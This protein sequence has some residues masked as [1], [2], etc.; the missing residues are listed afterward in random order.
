MPVSLWLKTKHTC[1]VEWT[2][3]ITELLR[4]SYAGTVKAMEAKCPAHALQ[5]LQSSTA[6][7]SRQGISE[8][9]Q[10]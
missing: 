4:C 10:S 9:W 8:S 2:W 3:L 7:C 6:L 1:K 5:T